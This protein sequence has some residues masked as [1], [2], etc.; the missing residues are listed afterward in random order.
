MHKLRKW[1]RLYVLVFHLLYLFN[2]KAKHYILYIC[3]IWKDVLVLCRLL[4]W[5]AEG[6]RSMEDKTWSTPR[7]CRLFSFFYSLSSSSALWS[8][9]VKKRGSLSV[10]GW[11]ENT[12]VTQLK[13]F[14]IKESQALFSQAKEAQ[15]RSQQRE[16]LNRNMRKSL[17]FGNHTIML[18]GVDTFL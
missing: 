13:I 4:S 11:K 12:T 15:N 3:S 10:E 9:A 7:S 14:L 2:Q 18:I 17:L 1:P 6:M 16:Q 5:P 8:G